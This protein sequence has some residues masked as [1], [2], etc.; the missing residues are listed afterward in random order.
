MKDTGKVIFPIV[1]ALIGAFMLAADEVSASLPGGGS[2]KLAREVAE[3]S[4][5]AADAMLEAAKKNSEA[6]TAINTALT[7]S[8]EAFASYREQVNERFAALDEQPVAAPTQQFEQS[9]AAVQ[10][11]IE[12]ANNANSAA[13]IESDALRNLSRGFILQQ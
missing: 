12:A 8:Q 3:Q 4:S 2:V 1:L 13:K 10:S 5:D 9:R 11:K 7:D 6:I